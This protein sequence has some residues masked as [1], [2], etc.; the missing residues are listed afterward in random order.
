MMEKENQKNTTKNSQKEYKKMTETPIPPLILSLA[1]PTIASMLISSVYNMA[2]TYFVARL[3]T[4][5]SG[6]VGIVF[7]LM[8][9]IQSIGFMIGMG[10]G[11][12]IS[13]TLGR[14]KKKEAD[15]IASSGFCCALTAGI[16]LM[17]A[18]TVMLKPLMALLGATDTIL[19]YAVSYG[20][21][22]LFGAPVLMGSFV[23]NNI[24]RAEGRAKLAMIGIGFGGILNIGLDPLF[25]FV[26]QLGIAGAAIAT[27]ISQCISFGILLFFFLTGKSIT[28]L[29]MTAVSRRFADYWLII[30][31]GLPSFCRQALASVATVALNRNV[32]IYGDEAVAAMAIVSKIFMVI[33]SVLIGFGQGY[34]PVCGYNYGAGNSGRVR[35]AFSFTAI[36]GTCFMAAVAVFGFFG[37]EMIM[38]WFIDDPAVIQIGVTAFR[39]QCI[40]MPLVPLGAICNMSLQ[41]VGKTWQG[42][43]LSSARQGIFFL[44]LVYLLPRYFGLFGA[45]ITQAAAD[46]CTFLMSIPF[47]IGFL[48]SL[49]NH[50][51]KEE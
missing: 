9:L 23:L 43:I 17:L 36:T 34:Q 41:V 37:A 24:L 19:P 22:I 14:Q 29:S 13:R 8:A 40:A 35:K 11:S 15:S 3:G 48:H 45:E 33:F 27:L 20:R 6:A 5:A 39:A 42:T 4:S 7:S 2:D 18:G 38:G 32:R 12:V 25:I 44:P 51:H 46:G 50:Q 10:S 49:N 30:K 31:T 16:L 26:F 47:C 21:Y 28:R 1:V